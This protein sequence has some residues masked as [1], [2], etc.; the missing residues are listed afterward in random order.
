MKRFLSLLLASTMT[1][2]LAGCGS[3][4]TS[5]ASSSSATTEATTQ[6]T[7]ASSTSSTSQP[8]KEY[9]TQFVLKA[10]D[11]MK[12]QG[13]EDVVLD[14][15]PQRIVCLSTSPVLALYEMGADMIMVPST[16][17]LNYPDDLGAEV[18]P[19]L[20]ADD[21]DLE[22]I[23]A[24]EPELAFLPSTSFEE[25]APILESAGIAC[26]AV[27]FT[28]GDTDHYGLIKEETE[29]Y[30]QAFVVDAASDAKA[31]AVMK[32]FEDLEAKMASAKSKFQDKVFLSAMVTGD[33][34]FVQSETSTLGS[35]MKRLGFQ[36]QYTS[37]MGESTGFLDLE[38]VV[39]LD[40]DVMVFISST[41][42]PEI[43]KQNAIDIMSNQQ[44]VWDTV[45]ALDDGRVIYLTTN[46]FVFGGIQVIDSIDSL[47]DLLLEVL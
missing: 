39:D 24:A 25:F 5:S 15:V 30:T 37:V 7:T 12:A 13:F 42:D 2:S 16:T 22:N 23:I 9:S 3:S 31:Q 20:R 26:Y 47:I 35:V 17:V 36:N 6:A 8:E 27:P 10:L 41:D 19:A 14:K 32:R 34:Y 43:S 28:H 29:V 21:F 46:Y 45:Q 4:S 11:S 18:I 44:E 1:L 33:N 40:V 38:N